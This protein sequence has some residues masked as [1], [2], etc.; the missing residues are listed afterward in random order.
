[1]NIYWQ[2]VHP[3]TEHIDALQFIPYAYGIEIDTFQ[4]KAFYLEIVT[5]QNVL[6]NQNW[7]SMMIKKML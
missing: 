6:D 4:G 7:T 3:M 1:M 5:G 2:K